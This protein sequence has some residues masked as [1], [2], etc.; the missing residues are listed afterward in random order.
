MKMTFPNDLDTGNLEYYY[1][2][3]VTCALLGVIL[4]FYLTRCGSNGED[5][6]EEVRDEEIDPT[7]RNDGRAH[8]E[9]RD[10]EH[11]ED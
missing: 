9:L 1:F 5:I 10:S 7:E 6:R 3:N 11:D 2:V 4:Y 8:A